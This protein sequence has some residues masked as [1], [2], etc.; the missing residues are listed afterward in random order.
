MFSWVLLNFIILRNTVARAASLVK[1][2][3]TNALFLV[4]KL[5]SSSLPTFLFRFSI[6]GLSFGYNLER[7]AGIRN[8][9]NSSI[10]LFP[11][12]ANFGCSI[13]LTIRYEALIKE[14]KG[15]CLCS[16]LS[17]TALRFKATFLSCL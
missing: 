5:G 2:T 8:L 4:I 3:A 1:V 14:S 13:I 9:M 17:K 15:L 11:L 12:L 16:S 6:R 10:A 7:P